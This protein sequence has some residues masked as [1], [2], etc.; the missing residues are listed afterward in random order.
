MDDVERGLLLGD[1]QH[2]APEREVVRDE[3]GDRLRLAG[4]GRPVEDERLAHRG[5]EDGRKLRR[6]GRK[7][8]EELAVLDVLRDL[9]GRKHLDAVVVVAAALHEVRDERMRREL[10]GAGRE[11]LPHHEL[12]EREVADGGV[13]LDVPALHALHR[14]AERREHLLD[15]HAGRVLGQR[16]EPLHGKSELGAEKL[17]ERRVEHGVVV[18]ARD[19]IAFADVLPRHLHRHEQDRRAAV[20]GVRALR[21]PLQEA[22]REVER[23]DAAFLEV[24]LG[25][26]ED[27]LESAQHV[28]GGERRAERARRARGRVGRLDRHGLVGRELVLERRYRIDGEGEYLLRVACVQQAVAEREVE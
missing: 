21:L 13:L 6:V 17:D 1:E 10:V 15:I 28:G 14:V 5:V 27:L 4:A 3:V 23:V 12:A 25:E 8:G 11:V 18:E 16:V 9:L 7:R 2:L 24:S 26:A 20:L 19:G 22:D